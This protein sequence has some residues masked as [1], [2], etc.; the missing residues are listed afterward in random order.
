ML[1]RAWPQGAAPPLWHDRRAGP[2]AWDMLAEAPPDLPEAPATVV[3]LAGVTPKSRSGTLDENTALALAAHKAASL[4]GARHLFVASTSAV[5][6]T[7]AGP[8]HEDT[9]LDPQPGY[10]AAKARMEESLLSLADSGGPAVTVLR[11]GN[12][13]GAGEPFA[14]AERARRGGVPL[15][16]DRFADGGGPSRNFIGPGTLA[17]VLAALCDHAVRGTPLPRVLNVGGRRPQEMAD[18]LDALA[19]PWEW[20]PAPETAI[21]R[22]HLDTTRLAALFDLPAQSATDVVRDAAAATVTT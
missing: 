14:S 8:L 17:Q 19:C 5:Y 7:G 9:P 1:R 16:L 21:K 12:V 2:L 3:C 15:Q 4:W 6:G 18:I 20:R 10:G 22:L 13:A 11:I